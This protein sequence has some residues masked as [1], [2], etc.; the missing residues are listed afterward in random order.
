MEN[1]DKNTNHP[2]PSDDAQSLVETIIPSTED[3]A[4]TTT[5]VES[6]VKESEEKNTEAGN[7]KSDEVKP[8]TKDSNE[9]EGSK[10]DEQKKN[11]AGDKIETVAP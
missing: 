10:Q 1:R 8:D 7:E 4:S 9:G 5:K 6:E 3:E 2:K 11:D